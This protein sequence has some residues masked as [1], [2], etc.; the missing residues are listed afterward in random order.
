M[1]YIKKH[2]SKNGIADCE[3]I[4]KVNT[5]TDAIHYLN[6]LGGNRI[7]NDATYVG[8]SLY[9]ISKDKE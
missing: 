2:I 5:Y 6:D 3:V 7:S 4:T 1:F 9:Y 8:G